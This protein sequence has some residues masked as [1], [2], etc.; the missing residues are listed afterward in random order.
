[1][2]E[3]K[4]LDW[5]IR[6]KGRAW[7]RDEAL[8]RHDLISGSCRIEMDRGKLLWSDEDR[9]ILLGLLLENVGAERAVMLGDPKAWRDAIA[10]LDSGL[11]SVSTEGHG[12]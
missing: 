3:M 2:A 10:A 1:M 11:A 7:T 5:D 9:L 8:A 6:L 4:A 12:K